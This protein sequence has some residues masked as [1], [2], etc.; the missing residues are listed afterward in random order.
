MYITSIETQ[1]LIEMCI[2]NDRKAQ[3]LLYKKFASRLYGTA[4]RYT[5][6]KDDAQEVLQ[7][8]FIKIF[9][10][11]KNYLG[12][13]SL[14]GWMKRIVIRTAIE[15]L[16][17]K[18]RNIQ[19]EPMQEPE[20]SDW[21]YSFAFDQLNSEEIMKAME[22]MPT[23]YRMVLNMYAIEGYSH[24]EIAEELKINEGTSKSQ[25]ARARKYLYEYLEEKN[26]IY[27]KL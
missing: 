7:D 27:G 25:L 26:K 15:Q 5:T 16:R 14:E 19:F 10:N 13:G 12:T 1:Y 17:K 3:A 9:K 20:L 21:T 22:Q 18:H 24:K 2:K 4:L 11:L 6:N 23:G 8:A